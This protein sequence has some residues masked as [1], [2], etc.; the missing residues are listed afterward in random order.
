M[1]A[2]EIRL[3]SHPLQWKLLDRQQV[4]E[5]RA[6]QPDQDQKEAWEEQQTQ[7]REHPALCQSQ[8]V[9][10]QEQV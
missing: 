5:Q 4:F 6:R 9:L 1:V 7:G 10:Y 2:H 3:V 8:R